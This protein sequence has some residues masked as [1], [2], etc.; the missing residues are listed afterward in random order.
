MSLDALTAV[1]FESYFVDSDLDEKTGLKADLVASSEVFASLEWTGRSQIALELSLDIALDVL[2]E[3]CFVVQEAI[4]SLDEQTGLEAGFVFSLALFVLLESAGTLKTAL[5]LSLSAR[6][7]VLS[8]L[9]FVLQAV[10]AHSMHLD[11]KTVL[12]DDF[13][14]SLELLPSLESTERSQTVLELSL[15]ATLAVLL[16]FVFL[17]ETV[18][19]DEKTALEAEQLAD[20]VVS[21]ETVVDLSSHVVIVVLF[22]SYFVYQGAAG[23]LGEWLVFVVVPESFA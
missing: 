17:E 20:F 10:T 3:L 16:E 15:A 14:A 2:S 18:H 7:A 19:W 1:L 21:F 9:Y 13:V 8:E 6:T 11:E 22:E 5:G 4:G 12:E 23:D